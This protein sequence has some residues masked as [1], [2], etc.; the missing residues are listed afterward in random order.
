MKFNT[1]A[2]VL[3]I[4]HAGTYDDNSVPIMANLPGWQIGTKKGNNLE[5]RLFYDLLCPYSRD[6]HTN[7]LQFLDEFIANET[8]PK[9]GDVMSVKITPIVLPYHL[10]SFQVT[11][12][13]P[14]LF[15]LCESSGGQKCYM[16]DYASLCFENL[17]TILADNTKIGRAH[18]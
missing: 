12:V 6:H 5:V 16:D 18:V 11:Q 8:S 3:S 14:F 17:S 13:V 7:M 15:D 10:H 9:Y 4:A 2:F 1:F